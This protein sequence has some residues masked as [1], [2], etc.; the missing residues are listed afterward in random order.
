MWYYGSLGSQWNSSL[1]WVSINFLGSSVS[2]LIVSVG[3]HWSSSSWNCIAGRSLFWGSLFRENHVL[4]TELA[5]K[6]TWSLP[7]SVQRFEKE[8]L[9]VRANTACVELPKGI[10]LAAVPLQGSATG[11]RVLSSCRALGE[12]ELCWGSSAPQL[13]LWAQC[14]AALNSFKLLFKTE[15]TTSR[16]LHHSVKSLSFHCSPGWAPQDSSELW[17][18][19]WHPIFC[20]DA[21]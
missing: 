7:T 6:C 21:G 19:M 11:L 4:K 10:S 15:V 1:Q 18:K 9:W 8:K 16:K 12:W 13:M 17:V 5:Y 2:E 20:R 14:W 3:A